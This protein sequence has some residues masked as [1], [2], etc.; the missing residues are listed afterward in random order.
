[1]WPTAHKYV[2]S[3]VEH[4]KADQPVSHHYGS[5]VDIF[6]YIDA[7]L[8]GYYIPVFA[9]SSRILNPVSK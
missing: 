8:V 5:H 9:L 7:A 2:D 4:F 3:D 1:M 6:I